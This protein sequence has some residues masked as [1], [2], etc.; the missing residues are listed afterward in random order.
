MT[1]APVAEAMSRE[2]RG[3]RAASEGNSRPTDWREAQRRFVRGGWFWLATVRAGGAP[4][5]VPVL[6]AWGGSTFFVA[7]KDSAR[8]SRHLD[9]DGRCVLSHDAGDMHLVVEG[10]ARRVAD[11]A[12]L[13]RASAAFA[14]VYDWP[15]RVS[16]GKLDADY[17]AY[18]GRSAVRRLRGDANQGVRFPDRR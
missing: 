17:G 11:E 10:T 3:T 15:T 1:E 9:A 7:S 12:A 13:T 5:V 6:A 16:G 18:L 2:S 8:K 14:T 4:H